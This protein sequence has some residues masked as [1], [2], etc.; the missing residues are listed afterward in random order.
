MEI[1]R[2]AEAGQG[3]HHHGPDHRR[4]SF[5]RGSPATERLR[6]AHRDLKDI[7]A[8]TVEITPTMAAEANEKV[9]Q[10]KSKAEQQEHHHAHDHQSGSFGR[11][12]CSD[13]K[14]T[15]GTHWVAEMTNFNQKTVAVSFFLFFACIAPAI[16]F[17][18]I[19]AKFTHNWIGAV[20][21]IAATAWVGISYALL[22]GQPIMINGGT[23][24][25]LA[26][27]GVIYKMSE[28]MEIPFL[29]LNAW[30][31]IWVGIYMFFAA[32]FDL[33]RFMHYA[34]RFTD[35]I[36]SGLISA[37][38]IINAIGSF[39]SRVGVLYYF[40]DALKASETI[41][42]VEVPNQGMY[43]SAFLAFVV[44]IG[45]TWLA[46]QLQKVKRSPYLCN[47]Y[48]R[49]TITDFG[50]V[51]SIAIWTLI[52]H[53]IFSDVPTEELAAPDEF[54][55]TF[56]CCTEACTLNW[57]EECPELPGAWGRR[58]WLVDLGDL[59]GKGWVPLFAAIPATLAFILVFLDNGITWHLI[60]RPENHLTH[61]SAYNY[62]TIVIGIT[63]VVNSFFGLPWLVAATVRS[64]NHLYAM[65]DKDGKTGKIVYVQQTRLTHLFIHVIVL[66]S[67]FAM[68]VV[69]KITMPVLYGV[70]LYM[71]I[72]SLGSNQFVGRVMMF[73]MQPSRYPKCGYTEHVSRGQMQR[74]TAVQLFLFVLLYFVKS[75]KSIAILFPLVIAACIPVRVWLLPR[76]FTKEELIYIDG[77]DAEIEAL[78]EEEARK[79]MERKEKEGEEGGWDLEERAMQL[80]EANA[81]LEREEKRRARRRRGSAGEQQVAE[82]RQDLRA[83]SEQLSLAVEVKRRNSPEELIVRRLVTP[84]IL[85]RRSQSNP[86]MTFKVWDPGFLQ[87]EVTRLRK[88]L[89]EKEA[90][91][92][93]GGGQAVRNGPGGGG[94]VPGRKDK[95]SI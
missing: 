63:V 43:A 80:A 10:I 28:S 40:D 70:F 82:L 87:Q 76:Y 1:P 84:E 15:V 85:V 58:P 91:I 95:V 94:G 6:S 79:L 78:E 24:P 56:E 42:G 4:D 35:D 66:I 23:G 20:E 52:D 65:A 30:I 92:A 21:M 3:Q 62:D 44:C 25:V 16:T 69:K 34:T 11:G 60:N 45:T 72:M 86:P 53:F 59:N 22:G 13:F 37:I 9:E 7:Y 61:G 41:A 12:I 47:Q 17:G 33:N 68:G 39:T 26:F 19:Y 73:F 38:F 49:T 31:G 71:G 51:T 50:V 5:D 90:G 88:L 77:D 81:R 83:A 36:F 2:A 55:P 64:M 74:F 93:D 54:G 57:P 67:I 75:V 32:F 14:Q 18:A 48:A 27:T 46:I 29:P 8:H 89:A